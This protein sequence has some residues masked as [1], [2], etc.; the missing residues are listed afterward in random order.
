MPIATP[1]KQRNISVN[2]RKLQKKRVCK[3]GKLSVVKSARLQK[4]NCKSI[5]KHIGIPT[6]MNSIKPEI[7]QLGCLTQAME[8]PSGLFT[9][10]TLTELQQIFGDWI[11]S[12]AGRYKLVFD[13]KV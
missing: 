10:K 12:E 1:V 7:P 13:K 3:G 4:T 2:G 5:S 9:N 6:P 11:T 8:D